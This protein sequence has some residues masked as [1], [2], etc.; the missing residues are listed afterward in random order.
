MDVDFDDLEDRNDIAT[1]TDIHP[2]TARVLAELD[3]KVSARKI[4]IPTR[5]VDV[6]ARLRSMREPVTLFGER[7]EDRRD[8][9]RGI[10]S[11]KNEERGDA[12]ESDESSDSGIDDD[13]KDEEFYTE[14][15]LELKKA[16][17]DIASY[18]IQRY[19]YGNPGSRYLELTPGRCV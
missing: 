11:K 13:E 16:R 4:A 18:S 15:T 3:R 2:D 8:R 9:L 6:R 14:G 1:S 5:D 7:P 17:G 10:V 19:V 12:G